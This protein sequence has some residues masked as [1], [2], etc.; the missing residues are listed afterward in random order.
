MKLKNLDENNIVIEELAKDE[1][2]E[3]I[4]DEEGDVDDQK[5][6]LNDEEKTLEIT[7]DD[8]NPD[9]AIISV[10]TKP[11]SGNETTL[12]DNHQSKLPQSNLSLRDVIRSLRGENPDFDNEMKN[13][14]KDYTIYSYNFGDQENL[15]LEDRIELVD[16]N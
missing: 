15:Q 10:K 7:D 4:L 1:D 13:L 11:D 16:K 2:K 5:E 14:E 3:K 9:M 8:K 6:N 12:L